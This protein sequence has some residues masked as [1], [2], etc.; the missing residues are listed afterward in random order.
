MPAMN[1]SD[2]SQKDPA[3][4]TARIAELEALMREQNIL[5]NEHCDA[6]ALLDPDGHF[7]YANQAFALA[8]GRDAESLAE[9]TITDVFSK[10][11]AERRSAVVR[12]ALEQRERVTCEVRLPRNGGDHFL[13][14]TAQPLFDAQGQIVSIIYVSRDITELRQLEERLSRMAQYDELTDLPNRTLFNDRLLKAIMQARRWCTRVALL[15]VD[16]DGF[17]AINESLGRPLG[18]LLLQMTA[19]RILEA[20]RE[21]DSVGRIGDDEFVVLLPFADEETSALVVADKIRRAINVPFAL[22]ENQQA[23]LS[24]CIGIA[25]Y[26]DHGSDEFQLYKRADWALY[27]A[28]EYGNDQTRV[29]TPKRS[30]APLQHA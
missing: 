20:V 15:L 27:E 25:I 7:R 14:T 22:P 11:D 2:P 4:L 6:I 13:T 5:L 30:E 26:P 10:S 29:F 18:D 24:A 17:G 12:A 21:S 1:A 8:A 3:Q 28:K 16:L 23:T 9:Y 19:S